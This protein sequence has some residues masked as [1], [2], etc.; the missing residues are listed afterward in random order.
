MN[1]EEYMNYQN[2][3]DICDCEWEEDYDDYFCE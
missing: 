3:G 2:S 1:F